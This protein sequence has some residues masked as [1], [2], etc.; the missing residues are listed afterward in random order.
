[1]KI[2]IV[3]EQRCTVFDAPGPNQEVDCLAD[4]DPAPAQK[5][6]IASAGD[7]N[8]IPGHRYDFEAAK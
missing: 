4:C 3:V 7:R 1:M 5:T 8:R 6:E 2:A